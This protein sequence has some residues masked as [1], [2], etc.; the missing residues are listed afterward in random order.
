MIK[1]KILIGCILTI[2][3]FLGFQYLRDTPSH[4]AYN[5]NLALNLSSGTALPTPKALPEFKL[6]DHN[7]KLF[8]H[9]QLFDV[10]WLYTMPWNMPSHVRQTQ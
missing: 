4:S 2:A 10:F 7:Q 1:S 8:S 9:K 3:I 6:V 5:P